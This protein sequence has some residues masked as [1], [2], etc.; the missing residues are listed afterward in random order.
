MQYATIKANMTC[1]TPKLG[2]RPGITFTSLH[3]QS[4]LINFTFSNFGQKSH[5]LK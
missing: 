1:N 2:D 3:N 5:R 4:C